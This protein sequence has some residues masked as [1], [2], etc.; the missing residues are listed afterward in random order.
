M[1]SRTMKFLLFRKF[2]WVILFSLVHLW[3][4]VFNWQL[5]ITMLNVNLGVGVVRL[6]PF[7]VLFLTGFVILVIQSWTG[8]VSKLHRIIHELEEELAQKNKGRQSSRS[9]GSVVDRVAAVNTESGKDG[10][11]GRERVARP[12]SKQQST[13][14][15]GEKKDEGKKSVLDPKNP[16]L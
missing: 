8:Y 6:P 2:I 12:E 1:K 10:I 16:T 14:E 15:R 11:P 5:F 13:A 7:V 4:M 9:S 3:F